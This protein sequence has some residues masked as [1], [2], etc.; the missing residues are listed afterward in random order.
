MSSASAIP[1]SHVPSASLQKEH[2]SVDT[3][4]NHEWP[5]LVPNTPPNNDN[6]VVVVENDWELLPEA[7]DDNTNPVLSSPKRNTNNTTVRIVEPAMEPKTT[8]I[9]PRLLKHC[10]SSPDLRQYVLEETS[11]SEGDNDEEEDE[12]EDA[13]GVLVENTADDVT[14]LASSSVVMVSSATSPW[15]STSKLSFKDVILKSHPEGSTTLQQQQQ[16]H[17][18]HH[19]HHTRIRKLKKPVFVVKPIKRCS[20]STGDLTSL[21]DDTGEYV[22]SGGGG[23]GGGRC[24]EQIL[25]ETDAEQFYSQKAQGKLGRKNGKKIRPDE[26]KRL[27]ITMAKK[28]MQREAIAAAGG[29][30]KKSR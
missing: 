6:V 20:R 16:P 5:A 18:R 3:H 7:T 17:K 28:T 25:G 2:Q 19:H 29:G 1:P 24:E 23:G 27:E 9:N 11:S 10:E 13:S 15:S 26:A 8:R 4:H 14:S 30:K 21:D 12:D 22:S